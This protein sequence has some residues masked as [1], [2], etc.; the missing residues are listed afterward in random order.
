MGINDILSEISNSRVRKVL[1]TIKRCRVRWASGGN[2]HSILI[3][4]AIQITSPEI[5]HSNICFKS[6]NGKII[7]LRDNNCSRA[8]YTNGHIY[9]IADFRIIE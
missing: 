4:N 9:K 6:I 8:N 1:E 3:E 2:P 7:L 5:I